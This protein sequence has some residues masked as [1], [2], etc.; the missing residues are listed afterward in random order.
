[1]GPE[2]NSHVLLQNSRQTKAQGYYCPVFLSLHKT[3]WFQL[4]ETSCCV[5]PSTTAGLVYMLFN[6]LKHPKL[7]DM[8]QSQRQCA[9][10]IKDSV[11]SRWSPE[12]F[13]TSYC[14]SR[15]WTDTNRNQTEADSLNQ[16]WVMIQTL[17]ITKR[18]NVLGH[19]ALSSLTSE[20]V[21]MIYRGSILVQ[22]LINLTFF[23][24]L[25]W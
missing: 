1:M 21:C 4:E 12:N 23:V 16:I 8:F 18:G 14:R 25:Q 22:F 3:S 10:G 5:Q 6:H 17:L 7:I 15:F 19:G 13:F 2:A 9:S 24:C 20:Q 11:F